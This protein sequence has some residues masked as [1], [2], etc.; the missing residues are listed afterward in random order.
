MA[1]HVIIR[2]K[3]KATLS[4]PLVHGALPMPL[5][6]AVD[7]VLAKEE[8]SWTHADCIVAGHAYSWALCHL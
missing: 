7:P 2:S 4:D 8:S 5:Q 6:E 1:G 3:T